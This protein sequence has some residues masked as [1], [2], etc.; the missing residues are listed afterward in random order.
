MSKLSSPSRVRASLAL[1]CVS[2]AILPFTAAALHAQDSKQGEERSLGGVTVS[3]TAI[4]DVEVG[5]RQASPRRCAPCATHP[6]PSP[7]S[8][9]R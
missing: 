9:A 1:S 4:D 2:T 5:R 6:R 7:S 8:R 3:D